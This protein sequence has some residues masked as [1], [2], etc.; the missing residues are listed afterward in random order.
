MA[1]SIAVF[2]LSAVVGWALIVTTA[3]RADDGPDPIFEKPAAISMAELAKRSTDG[4][5]A[6]EVSD[7]APGHYTGKLSPSP[8]HADMNPRKAVVVFWKD[9][10]ERF[11]FSHEASYCPILELPSGAAMCNQFFEGNMGNAELFNS[12]GRKEKNS[13]VDIVQ[14]G[15]RRVWVRWN[16]S[17]VNMT[18]D[19]QPR[20]RGTEDYIAYPNGLVWRR[21]T[22]ESLMP[23][24]MVGYATDPVEL[25]GVAPVG[26]T[27]KDLFPRD[28]EHG[29][30][31][32]HTVLDL[33][34]TKRYDIYWDGKGKV[35]RRGDDT[36]M[37]AITASPGCALVLPFRDKLLFAVLGEASGF[38][39]QKNQL[40]DHCT[41]G[42][43]GGCGWQQGL[44]DHWPIGWLNSQTSLWKP[45]SPY[46]YSF[47]SVGQFF[48]PEGKRIKSFMKDYSE[49]CKDMEFNRWTASRVSYVLLGAAQSWDDVRRIGRSW[50]DKGK[51]C[52]KPESIAEL[53]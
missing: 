21:A 49:L 7:Y 39:S 3:A 46:S 23:N 26:S 15:P 4:V 9:R 17:A 31:L 50:L 13:F 42:A 48:V 11:V 16:Y 43:E 38:P 41:P 12:M 14:S 5:S 1:T 29:D 25:F 47:G 28:A 8:P 24:E 33:Y 40:V 27:I 37:A 6:L 44:W 36:T 45:G 19:S 2:A 35:R 51:Q 30:Y 52:A 10:A 53:K 18:D 22:Y 32:T 34:S 20:L